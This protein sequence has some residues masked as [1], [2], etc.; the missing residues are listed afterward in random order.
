M[1]WL[2]LKGVAA[3]L[4]L[5]KDA[6]HV[7]A[8]FAIQVAAALVMRKSLGHWGPWLMVLGFAL[9]NESLDMLLGEE[10]SIKPW[11]VRGA[12]HDLVNTMV[13]PTALLILSRFRP[14]LFS[15]GVRTRQPDR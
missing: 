10:A 7:Y 12:A 4:L 14:G 13:L 5:E 11:Q 3:T 8:A 1:D 2:G 9:I 6:L 15:A